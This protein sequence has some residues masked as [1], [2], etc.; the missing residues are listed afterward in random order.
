MHDFYKKLYTKRIFSLKDVL[1]QYKNYQVSKNYVQR[2]L[3]RK[4]AKRIRSGLYYIVPIDNEKYVPNP[5]SIGADLVSPYYFSTITALYL[6]GIIKQQTLGNVFIFSKCSKAFKYEKTTYKIRRTRH[7]FGIENMDFEGVKV[8]VTDKERTFIDCL[9]SKTISFKS[10]LKLV[11]DMEINF[12]RLLKYLDKLNNKFLYAKCGFALEKLQYKNVSEKDLRKLKNR[13][14]KK[15]Y[16]L[17]RKIPSYTT[18]IP[19]ARIR[20]TI[21]RFSRIYQ[22]KHHYIKRWNLMV[23]EDIIAYTTSEET[24]QESKEKQ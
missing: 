13:T 7:F 16:Y 9:N 1:N 4:E 6:H 10:F 18:L 24:K 5:I 20:K 3:K 17:E 12:K 14:G 8:K 15:I 19:G 2:L 11:K 22:Q 23:P 21:Y